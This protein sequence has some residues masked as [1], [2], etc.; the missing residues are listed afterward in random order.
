MR[1]A[2]IPC[3]FAVACAIAFTC[4]AAYSANSSLPEDAQLHAMADEMLRSK[5]L[6]LN[7]LDKPYFIQYS[8]NDTEEIVI[9]ASLGGITRSTQVH[10]RQPDVVVRV[11]DYSFDNTNSIFAV[12]PRFGL[13]PLDDDYG[14]MRTSLWRTTDILYKTATDQITRKRNALREISDPDKTAD[15]APAKTVHIIEPVTKL[16][17]DKQSWQEG[18]RNASNRFVSH[19]GVITSSL[20][21]RTIGSTYR[22]V[23]S[24]GTTLRIPENLSELEIRASGR[25]AD[26]KRVWNHQFLTALDPQDLPKGQLTK[27]ADDIATQTE[28]LVKAPQAEE[29]SGPVLFEGEAAAQMMAQILTDAVTLRR[30]PVIPPGSNEAA[31]QLI[32]SV[33]SSRVGS[34]IGPDWLTIFDDPL[35]EKYRAVA[36]AGHYSVDDEGVPAQRVELVQKGMFKGFLLSRV[37]I[38]KFSGSN[39]H[40]RLPGPFGSEEAAFGNLFVETAHPVPETALKARLLDKVKAAGLKYGLLMRRIDFPSTATLGDLQSMARQLQKNG[41]ARTLNHPLLAYRVYADGH[42]ELVRGLRFGEFSAKDLRDLDS[43][44]DQPYVFNYV[45]NGS[46]LNIADLRTDATTSSVICP[47][48]LFESV[49]LSPAENEAGAPPVVPPPALMAKQ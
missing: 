13:F 15:F 35:Q 1:N 25:S 32:E 24:E 48:L 43:A 38:R 36:L 33:W 47:S 31:V 12:R 3:L 14:A 9:A 19:P 40:G 11:G 49:D 8:T 23:N 29:Y 7:K 6:V 39:G 27:L 17:L 18:L 42:E 26:G 30:K 16:D 28:A 34:K 20:R 45:N 4:A 5:T 41:F 22:L 46:S 10:V 44:S 2:S 21:I 37:P